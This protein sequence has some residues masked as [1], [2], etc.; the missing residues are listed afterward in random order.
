MS[1]VEK[2]INIAWLIPVE[3]NEFARCGS[4]SRI[5]HVKLDEIIDRMPLRGVPMVET[6]RTD[7]HQILKDGYGRHNFGQI[8]RDRILRFRQE[9]REA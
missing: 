9:A 2:T 5:P 7:M 6:L 1:N 8:V 4:G 3:A